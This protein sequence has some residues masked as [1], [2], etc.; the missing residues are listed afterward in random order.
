[1]ACRRRLAVIS[2]GPGTGKTT[3]VVKILALLQEQALAR[4]REPLRIVLVAPTG[5]AAQRLGESID[6]S[7]KALPV[8]EAVKRS[9]PTRASTIHRALGFMPATPTRFRHGVDRPL[10]ADVVLADEAS[11]IDLALMTK[12]VEAV[13]MDAHLIILGDKDQLSSIE[14]G[15]ILG[16]IYDAQARSNSSASALASCMVELTKS[17][18]YDEH[19]GIGALAGAINRGDPDAVMTILKGEGA[20]PYGEVAIASLDERYPFAGHLGKAMVD[21]YRACLTASSVSERLQ[22]MTR[23]RILC[24][25]R[26]G[27]L[28]VDVL[29]GLAEQ[30][31]RRAGLLELNSSYY[32]GRPIMITRNDH[33]LGLFN[34]DVGVIHHGDTGVALAWF[35][36]DDGPR[37][38]PPSRLPPHETVFAMTVHKSQGSEFDRV[39]VVL[40][41]RASPILTRELVYTGVSRAR[42]RVDIH[43]AE[44][45]LCHALGRRIERGSG[46]S[47]ALWATNDA[48]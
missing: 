14:A 39:A 2:G 19:S 45:V 24:A 16:D 6:G 21:G 31:L 36:G 41:S 35:A 25:H 43:G 40:P 10:C 37:A 13:A 46:L 5:K 18:R 12:L 15:A 1:M 27:P 20:M 44:H 9:I 23:F 33:Q 22:L 7:L 34:G 30:H 8:S 48:P 38:L 11:M 17:Y 3:T 47:D 32:D 29:N 28:G 26:R 4:S 42:S